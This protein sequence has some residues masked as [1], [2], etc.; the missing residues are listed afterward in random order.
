MAAVV[1]MPEATVDKNYL[2]ARYENEVGLPRKLSGVE[3]ITI[4]HGV[5]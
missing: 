5:S 1:L 3:P 2:S 4:A